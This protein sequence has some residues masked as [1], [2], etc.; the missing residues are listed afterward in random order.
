LNA[1]NF[2]D[3]EAHPDAW[4]IGFVASMITLVI[5]YW[6]PFFQGIPLWFHVFM[7]FS[8]LFVVIG[9]IETFDESPAD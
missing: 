9:V 7:F 2:F 3:I 6:L 1:R 5:S 4:L 8:L